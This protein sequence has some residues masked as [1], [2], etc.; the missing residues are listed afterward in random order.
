MNSCHGCRDLHRHQHSL[1]AVIQAE[2][3]KGKIK[4]KNNIKSVIRTLASGVSPLTTHS[5]ISAG[6]SIEHAF[7]ASTNLWKQTPDRDQSNS[8]SK[9]TREGEANEGERSLNP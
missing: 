1:K 8:F 2:T 6:A 7:A 5:S 9:S 4:R 3:S